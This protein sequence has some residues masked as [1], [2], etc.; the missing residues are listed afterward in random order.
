MPNHFH[1]LIRQLVDGGI[2]QG[3]S[4]LCN[5]YT[6]Y[7]NTRYHR[8]GPLFQGTFRAV[9]IRTDDLLVHV[10]RYI[11]L[12]PVVANLAAHPAA[13]HWSSYR[14]LW[15]PDEFTVPSSFLAYFNDAKQVEAFVLDHLDYARSLETIKHLTFD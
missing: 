10:C 4:E 13:Y 8:V 1:L 3:I 6:K 11:F 7:F 15:T 9:P 14:T 2:S 5:S 12:N